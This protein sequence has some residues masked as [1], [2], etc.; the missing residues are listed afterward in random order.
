MKSIS[1]EHMKLPYIDSDQRLHRPLALAVAQ[2]YSHLRTFTLG[3]S[4]TEPGTSCV[5]NMGFIPQLRVSPLLNPA[6]GPV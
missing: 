2:T 5:Q 1:A 6:T 4:Q 3:W